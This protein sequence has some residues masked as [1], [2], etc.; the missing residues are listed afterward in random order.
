MF[1]TTFKNMRNHSAYIAEIV[2]HAL[3]QKQVDQVYKINNLYILE[4]FVVLILIYTD[5]K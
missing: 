1:E 4:V 3:I 2:I 5:S